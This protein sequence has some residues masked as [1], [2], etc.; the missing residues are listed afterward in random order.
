MTIWVEEYM[1]MASAQ[2]RLMG[3]PQMPARA[4]TQ[5]SSGGAVSTI[6][7]DPGTQ[8][9][10]LFNTAANG[11]MIMGGVE[12]RLDG[13]RQHALRPAEPA[14]HPGR[15]AARQA[16]RVVNMKKEMPAQPCPAHPRQ[17]RPCQIGLGRQ[18]DRTV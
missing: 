17:N 1:A 7:L 15:E 6:A 5:V 16:V 10:A 4:V 8:F 2:E 3:V 12:H 18:A 9:V 11:F 13:D 14:H